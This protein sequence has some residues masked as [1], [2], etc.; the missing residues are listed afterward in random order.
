MSTEEHNLSQP[1]SYV[2]RRN[3]IKS[4]AACAL[5]TSIASGAHARV[6]STQLPSEIH[7]FIEDGI[8]KRMLGRTGLKVSAIGLGTIPTFRA[9]KKQAVEVIKKSYDSG[10]TFID[11]A[12]AY[13]D[14]YSEECVG[15]ALKGVRHNVVIVTKTRK[16]DSAEGAEEDVDISLKMLQTDY[17]DIY[18]FHELCQEEE[19]KKATGPKGALEGLKKAQKAG[20]IRFIGI[21]GH[22]SD[23]L[24]EI[25][26]SGE[27]DVIIIPYNYVFN[28][29]DGD[30]WPTCQELNIGMVGIKPFAGCFLNQHSLSLRYNLQKPHHVSVPGMWQ[31]DEVIENTRHLR[32]FLPLNETELLYLWEE[33]QYWYYQLC[34]FCYQC[35][36]CPQNIQYRTIL[37]IPLALR[38]QGFEL[39]LV[40]RKMKFEYLN[41]MDKAEQ[42]NKCGYCVETCKYHLPIPEI[43]K[44]VKRNYYNPIK[45][46]QI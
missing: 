22:R 1:F 43:I 25:A 33:R 4:A 13:R 34:R 41:N 30:L 44:E 15:E 27:M 26:K 37:M 10:I 32:E 20:K 2:S 19:W 42:C 36:P 8:L 12:R 24:T 45:Y 16:F 18:C 3:F 39:Q 14:G 9:P 11:T 6:P 23:Q 31:V 29:A 40:E 46:Y 28:D 21:S 7:G 5:G 17:I 35:K 38:R